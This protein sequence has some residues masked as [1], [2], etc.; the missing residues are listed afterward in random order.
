MSN[1]SKSV[2]VIAGSDP[3]GGAGI[4]ADLKTLTSIGVYGM[5]AITA[6]TEQNTKGVNSIFEIPVDFVIKQ[7]TC[8]L[9]D[10][11]INAVKIGMLHN[12]NLINA[13]YQTLSNNKIIA[14]EDIKIVLDPVMVAKGGHRLLEKNAIEAL[15]DFIKKSKPI[16]TPN[17]PEAEILTGYKIK[18][19]SDMKKAGKKLLELGASNVILKGGHLETSL[20]T[21]VL[22]DSKN[23]YSIETNKIS[24]S[25]TH[26][27][28]CTM[29]SAITGYLAKSYSIRNAFE[30]AHLY[31]NNAI[32][33]APK[34]GN[35]NGPI[36]HCYNIT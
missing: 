6:L 10:I 18:D 30:A 14:N 11:K 8:C 21:D 5:T 23:F 1:L 24:T 25:N 31:V 28:G 32:K 16:L 9:T 17:I 33:T 3:S 34:L 29:A 13:V 19:I 7:I 2:L 36:N 22:I 15:K 27:T 4:Q 20:L 26:G 12:V 35:G